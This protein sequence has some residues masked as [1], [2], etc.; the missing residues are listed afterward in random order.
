MFVSQA[1]FPETESLVTTFVANVS[2]VRPVVVTLLASFVYVPAASARTA[3][4]YSHDETPFVIDAFVTVTTPDVAVIDDGSR[5]TFTPP[6]QVVIMFEFVSTTSPVGNVS[7]N[8]RLLFAALPG[9]FVNVKIN[10]EI[11]PLATVDGKNLFV[12]VGKT[13]Y[14]ALITPAAPATKVLVADVNSVIAVVFSLVVVPPTTLVP[15]T[16]AV[17]TSLNWTAYVPGT[18]LGKLYCPELSVVVVI[19]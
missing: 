2:F 19:P 14:V 17:G 13:V 16:A 12:R 7:T 15:V 9:L 5:A 1:N 3:M 11:C 6:G 10:V 18:T 8:P 4:L